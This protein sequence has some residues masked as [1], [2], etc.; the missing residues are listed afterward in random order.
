MSV[1]RYWCVNVVL[2]WARKFVN[3]WYKAVQSSTEEE[4]R[5]CCVPN[6]FVRFRE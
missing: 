1:V 6:P 4:Y 2:L 5:V 3:L